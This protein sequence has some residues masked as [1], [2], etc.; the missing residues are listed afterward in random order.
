MIEVEDEAIVNTVMKLSCR[1]HT[2][3][4]CVASKLCSFTGSCIFQNGGRRLHV[5]NSCLAVLCQKGRVSYKN[6]LLD[7]TFSSF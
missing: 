5:L 6:C 2:L 3:P 1:L 7:Y 4:A